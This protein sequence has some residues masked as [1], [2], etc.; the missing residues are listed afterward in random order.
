MSL[1]VYIQFYYFV[2]HCCCDHVHKE[3]PAKLGFS[4]FVGVMYGLDYFFIVIR[5]ESSVT[6]HDSRHNKGNNTN[7][8]DSKEE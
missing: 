2:N 8:D 4:F 3:T 7:H 6:V 1:F 5:C